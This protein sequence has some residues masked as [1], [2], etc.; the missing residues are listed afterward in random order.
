MPSEGPSRRWDRTIIRSKRRKANIRYDNGSVCSDK[1]TQPQHCT[2]DTDESNLIRGRTFANVHLIL[3]HTYIWGP[4]NVSSSKG[5]SDR[6]YPIGFYNH[7]LGPWLILLLPA[8][9]Y[10][11]SKKYSQGILRVLPHSPKISAFKTPVIYDKNALT[12]A[13]DCLL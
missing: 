8:P 2:E 7:R 12:T 6:I 13:E 1:N 10:R 9:H 11:G 4:L 3:L 5:M